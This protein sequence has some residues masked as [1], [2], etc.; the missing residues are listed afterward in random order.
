M[1]IWK[2][3]SSREL[4][5]CLGPA[6]FKRWESN[7]G[8]THFK[9]LWNLIFF[10]PLLCEA[11]SCPRVG[12]QVFFP[13]LFFHKCGWK[14]KHNR[15]LWFELAGASDGRRRFPF[16][17]SHLFSSLSAHLSHPC[18]RSR[19][20]WLLARY[21]RAV[22]LRLLTTCCWQIVLSV[23]VHYCT[24]SCLGQHIKRIKDRWNSATN[25]GSTTADRVDGWSQARGGSL[26]L[27]V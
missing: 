26:I 23:L 4:V 14:E 3:Q 5:L 9:R 21:S 25:K 8:K 10:P 11:V 6:R 1:F 2:K 16:S 27:C 22:F 24:F 13:S 19:G 15:P 20:H 7:S 12:G 18:V 17:G